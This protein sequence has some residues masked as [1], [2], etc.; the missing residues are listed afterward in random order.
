MRLGDIAK[1]HSQTA[2]YHIT[3]LWSGDFGTYQSIYESKSII[4]AT[5]YTNLQQ[6]PR[7]QLFDICIV[8]EAGQIPEPSILQAFFLSKQVFLVGDSK[9]LPPIVQN[10]L[11][12]KYGFDISLL[13][14][15]EQSGNDKSE[16]IGKLYTQYRMNESIMNLVNHLIYDNTLRAASESIANAVLQVQMDS[17]VP[18]WIQKVLNPSN[19]VVFITTDDQCKDIDEQELQEEDNRRNNMYE[20]RIVMELIKYMRNG[21]ASSESIGV[22]SPYNTQ[23][24]SIQS[25]I[26]EKSIEISTVDSFQVESVD[27]ILEI[28]KGERLHYYFVSEK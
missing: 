6:F 15:L 24:S 12:A 14:R 8:D 1:I 20:T 23:V 11:A 9:Q 28:G 16:W 22:I 10:P 17:N 26:E 5:V 7:N 25:V 4:G 21:G 3:N 2:R 13:A 19:G 27:G 18:S